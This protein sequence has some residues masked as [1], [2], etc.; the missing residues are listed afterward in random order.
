MKPVEAKEGGLV[1]RWVKVAQDTYVPCSQ[2]HISMPLGKGFMRIEKTPAGHN[3]G[4]MFDH[5]SDVL[6]RCCAR[7]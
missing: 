6:D 2:Q 3:Q 1:D 5:S 7:S 4:G